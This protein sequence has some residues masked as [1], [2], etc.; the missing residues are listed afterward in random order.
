MAATC[1]FQGSIYGGVVVEKFPDIFSGRLRNPRDERLGTTIHEHL[2]RW[3]R[4]LLRTFRGEGR[5]V[6]VSVWLFRQRLRKVHEETGVPFIP[7]GL[8]KS[9][10]SYWIAG[11]KYNIGQV[12]KWAGG[13]EQSCRQYYLRLLTKADHEA[14]FLAPHEAE[15]IKLLEQIQDTAE[16]S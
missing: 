4:R 10:I 7:N 9:A 12:A 5:I 13:S 15:E 14:W 1:C 3:L 16:I 2:G 8:R 6:N 11:G